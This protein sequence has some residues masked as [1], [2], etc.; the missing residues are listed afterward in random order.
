MW[1]LLVSKPV[2]YN[3]I[4][5]IRVEVQHINQKIDDHYRGVHIIDSIQAINRGQDP[6][7]QDTI[8]V[9]EF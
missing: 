7:S 2:I 9:L 4:E 5:E 6:D 3:S 8:P 1:D